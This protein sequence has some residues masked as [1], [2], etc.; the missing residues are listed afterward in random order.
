MKGF[1]KRR[2]LPQKAKLGAESNP[3][4]IA[5]ESV[6]ITKQHW[7]TYSKELKDDFIPKPS[8]RTRGIKEFWKSG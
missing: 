3:S 7:E 4:Q 6:V 5:G 8:T 2:D 1:L